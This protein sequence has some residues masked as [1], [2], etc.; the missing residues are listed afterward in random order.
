[1]SRAPTAGTDRAFDA[2]V[3]TS[4]GA[5]SPD[6]RSGER[7]P[8]LAFVG[9]GWIG[10]ARL[11][12]LLDVGAGEVVALA[13]PLEAARAASR[14]LAPGALEGDTLDDVLALEPDGVV[15]ATP[16][17]LHAREAQ[18]ALRAGA[19]VF[20]QKPLGRTASECGA[21]VDT[22]RTANRL[23]GVDFCYR[24]TRAVDAV[25]SWVRSGELGR[26]Y[27]LDLTFHNAYG[28][29]KAWFYE[30]SRSGGGCLLDLGIHL[31][32][33]ALDILGEPR[34]VDAVGT[35][36]RHG[37]RVS[38]GSET[39]EDFATAELTFPSGARARIACSW[40][41][42]AGRDAVIAVDAWGTEGGA[43]IRNV[44]GS[45]YDFTAERFRGTAR[46]V[47]VE[48]PDSW[49][50]RGLVAW[51]SALARSPSYDPGVESVLEVAR[52]LDALYGE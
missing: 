13:D 49:G 51:A 30:R 3:R 29:D 25:R 4:Y 21:V 45:F 20:C 31:V 36:F 24:H 26:V 15:I 32:D 39:V 6:A 18:R 35:L 23:L 37:E 1:M 41:L 16:S 14:T 10:R 47:L 9:L 27:A 2:G 50:G 11:A 38:S 48:P 28:P 19:A 42:P 5:A 46:E 33:L 12:S 43:S 7:P 40:R 8:R 22:A 52:V 17:A 34:V 44:D